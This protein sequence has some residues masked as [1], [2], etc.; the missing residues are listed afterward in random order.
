MKPDIKKV[1]SIN[2]EEENSEEEETES[3]KPTPKPKPKNKKMPQLKSSG[4]YKKNPKKSFEKAF[5]EINMETQIKKQQEQEAYA[6]EEMPISQKIYEELNKLREIL[7]GWEMNKLVDLL[8]T[9]KEVE[10]NYDREGNFG[11][12]SPLPISP[13]TKPLKK[14]ADYKKAPP[15]KTA[16]LPLQTQIPNP[17]PAKF[18][19][20]PISPQEMPLPNSVS[21][22]SFSSFPLENLA[23]PLPTNPNPNEIILDNSRPEVNLKRCPNCNKKLKSFFGIFGKGRSKIIYENGRAKQT[24]FCKSC[25]WH[26]EIR[27]VI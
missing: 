23:T 24:L 10:I 14:L 1:I 18:Q 11:C 9:F 16:P 26:T 22:P 5:K 15:Q 21:F 7:E 13:S 3:E 12:S 8:S 2:D 19:Q 17:N 20:N 6:P 25:G 4:S 27:I